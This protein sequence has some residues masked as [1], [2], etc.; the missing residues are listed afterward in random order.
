M[1]ADMTGPSFLD[2]FPWLKD[3]SIV[4]GLWPW[5]PGFLPAGAD[6]GEQ[7]ERYRAAGFTHVSLTVA[8]GTNTALDAMTLLGQQRRNLRQAGVTVARS[9]EAIETQRAAGHFTA[10]F[11]FQSSTPFSSATDLVDG[12]FHAGVDRAIVAYNEANIFADGCH[13]PRNAGL[14]AR[15]R[16]LVRRMDEVGMR[17]DL[18]HCGIRTTMD[19]LAMDLRRPPLFSHSNARALFDH[20]RNITDDQ[21]RAAAEAGS[22][23]GLN[24]VGFF[25]GVDGPA[26]PDAIARHAAHIAERCGADRIGLGLDFMYLDGSDYGFFHAARG[27]WPRGY[28][29]PPWSFFQPEQLGDLVEALT[30]TGFDQSEIRGILG[31]NYLRLA[32]PE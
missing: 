20:E 29:D 12:F 8:S 26:I 23:V 9:R 18:T 16:E 4:D 11:H 24:G 28:P 10:S 7:A 14:S 15:G 17:I 13:E 31:E 25:L 1:D 32:L 27:R 22:Y 5:S 6:F 2:R 19:V 30:A 3:G 21:I